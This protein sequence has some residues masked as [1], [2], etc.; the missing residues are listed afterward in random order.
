[1]FEI[2]SLEFNVGDTSSQKDKK[3]DDSNSKKDGK[4]TGSSD[5][6]SVRNPDTGRGTITIT[7]SIDYSSPLLFRYCVDKKLNDEQPIDWIIVYCKEAGDDSGD[8][9]LRLEFREVGVTS[10]TW[11]LDPAANAEEAVK[12]EKIT[13]SFETMRIYYAQQLGTGKHKAPMTNFWNFAKPNEDVAP[14]TS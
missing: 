13:F 2:S 11:D 6:S 10:F 9:W 5:Q 3:K 7:K 1:M 12:M 14:I 4:H 8:P